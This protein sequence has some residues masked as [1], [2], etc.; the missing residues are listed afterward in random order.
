M[1]TNGHSTKLR[2]A[3]G[4]DPAGWPEDLRIRQFPEARP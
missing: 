2:H 3:K 1:R 4:G